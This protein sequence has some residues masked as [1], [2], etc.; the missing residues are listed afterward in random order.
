[1]SVTSATTFQLVATNASGTTSSNITVSV[2]AAPTVPDPTSHISTNSNTLPAGGGSVV[3]SWTTLNAT[4]ATLNGIP[5]ALTGSETATVTA[6]QTFTLIATNSDGKTATSSVAVTV[7]QPVPPISTSQTIFFDALQTGWYTVRSWAAATSIVSTPIYSGSK[8][9]K[10]VTTPWNSL[11]FSNGNW[12]AFKQ[13]AAST[14]KTFS[15]EIYNPNSSK[16]TVYVSAYSSTGKLK[17]VSFTIPSKTWINYAPL[18]SSLVGNSSYISL[19]FSTLGVGT[20]FY[21]DNVQLTNSI[22]NSTN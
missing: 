2:A 12:N 20:T 8:S 14:Y 10:V 15:F 9:L 19:E 18:I 7:T 13:I 22:A 3:L 4:S 21:L 6:T 1:L 16:I 11:Q 5:V 17:T